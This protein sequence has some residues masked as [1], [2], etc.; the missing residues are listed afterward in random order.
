MGKLYQWKPDMIRFMKDSAT[1]TGAYQ[2]MADAIDHLLPKGGTVCDVGC[3]L[4]H[5]AVALSQKKY[6][7][8]AVDV[9]TRA[10]EHLKNSEYLTVK[11][12]DIFLDAP[13][14]PYD[15]MVF[16]MFGSAEEIL[17]IAKKQCRGTVVVIRRHRRGARFSLDKHREGCHTFSNLREELEEKGVKYGE[18][19]LDL[20]MGQPLESDEDAVQFFRT[21]SRDDHPEA[22]QF[23]DIAERLVAEPTGNYKWYLPVKNHFGVLFFQ[24]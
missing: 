4:G 21:Y 5:L 13:G 8:T 18:F 7:V 11:N 3:G 9:S 14:K 16:C 10:T 2:K 6:A 22:I 24:I 15:S 20:E 1:Y 17:N 23:A 12:T 19:S